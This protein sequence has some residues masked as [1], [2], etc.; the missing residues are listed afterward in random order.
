MK[1]VFSFILVIFLIWLIVKSLP[2]NSGNSPSQGNTVTINIESVKKPD[3]QVTKNQPPTVP[4]LQQNEK[5]A[6]SQE[7]NLTDGI[8][9]NGKK[10]TP[11][12]FN[13]CYNQ[14]HDKVAY[15]NGEYIHI[16]PKNYICKVF[17]V[18]NNYEALL[19]SVNGQERDCHVSGLKMNMADEHQFSFR[20]CLVKNG[21]YSYVTILGAQRTV[22][23]FIIGECEPLTREEF[24]D[25]LNNGLV[26]MKDVTVGTKTVKQP[27]P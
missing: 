4:V 24:A 18:I 22:P 13:Y 12:W 3:E 8:I 10:R 6:P 20:G 14:F 21:V 7:S 5:I 9:Y 17:Q 19:S 25:A 26:L 11:A 15:V 2:R 1:K 23:S 16:S 27:I